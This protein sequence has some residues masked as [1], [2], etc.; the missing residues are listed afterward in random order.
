M[1][2]KIRSGPII[3]KHSEPRVKKGT[4]GGEKELRNGAPAKRKKEVAHTSGAEFFHPAV[5]KPKPER[6]ELQG[7]W[8]KKKKRGGK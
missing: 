2:A 4:V 8:G 6:K 1:I 7:R 3:R 5:S